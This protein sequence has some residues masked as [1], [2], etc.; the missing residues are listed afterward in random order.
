MQDIVA[1]RS[2]V[3]AAPSLPEQIARILGLHWRACLDGLVPPALPPHA[4]LDAEQI[5]EAMAD[6]RTRYMYGQDRHSRFWHREL[7]Y[8]ALLNSIALHASWA[9]PAPRPVGTALLMRHAGLSDRMVRLTLAQGIA[10]GDLV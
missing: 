2:A 3:S 1:L 8:L 6:P 7:A 5:R 9:N 10:T 4:R